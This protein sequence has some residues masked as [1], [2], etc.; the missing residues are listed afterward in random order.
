MKKED[1]AIGIVLGIIAMLITL[2]FG[3]MLAHETTAIQVCQSFGWQSGSLKGWFVGF[4]DE[5]TE[6]K[7]QHHSC[8]LEY[9]LAGEC[10]PM[11]SNAQ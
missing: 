9:V 4:C 5:Y 8:E 10:E 11:W 7:W 1:K 3:A 2:Y 6:D